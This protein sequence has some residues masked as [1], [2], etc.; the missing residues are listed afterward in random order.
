MGNPE[1]TLLEADLGAHLSRSPRKPVLNQS[2]HPNT[3]AHFRSTLTCEHS[4]AGIRRL[5]QPGLRPRRPANT[6]WKGLHLR[7]LSAETEKSHTAAGTTWPQMIG[8]P[9]LSPASGLQLQP[10]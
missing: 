5:H 6:C 8:N 9:G 1:N 3:S 7:H 2:P 4:L 10:F